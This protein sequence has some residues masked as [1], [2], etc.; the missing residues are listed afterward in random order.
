MK[1]VVNYN[2]SESEDIKLYRYG[3]QCAAKDI[4]YILDSLQIFFNN[5][6]SKYNFGDATPLFPKKMALDFVDKWRSLSRYS[7]LVD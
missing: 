3:L 2:V 6:T 5:E 4:Y 1:R 7:S